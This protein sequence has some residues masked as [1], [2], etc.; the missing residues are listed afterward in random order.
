MAKK[1]VYDFY[2]II[3]DNVVLGHRTPVKGSPN[4]AVPEGV[5]KIGTH[6]FE[7]EYCESV[8]FPSTLKTVGKEA[9]NHCSEL[10]E[11]II[12]DGVEE[13]GS[14]AFNNCGSL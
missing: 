7:G 13:L 9:F 2:G 11:V 4:I 14:R 3:E 5:V 8:I 12:P 10:R 6:A 1:T